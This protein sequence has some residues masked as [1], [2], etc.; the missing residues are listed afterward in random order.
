MHAIE[1]RRRYDQEERIRKEEIQRGNIFQPPTVNTN[2]PSSPSTSSA[3]TE[4]S[5]DSNRSS[6]TYNISDTLERF[7]PGHVSSPDRARLLEIRVA[8]MLSPVCSS[9]REML[10]DRIRIQTNLRKLLAV[11]ER[12]E[13]LPDA[14]KP[15]LDAS[16]DRTHFYLAYHGLNDRFIQEM[17]MTVYRRSIREL[18]WTPAAK[19]VPQSSALDGALDYLPFLI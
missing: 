2:H 19:A 13:L 12:D 5:T 4:C 1:T 8:V 16:L 11:S 10:G 7:E 9:W 6:S 14:A 18:E 15:S 3:I 17:V